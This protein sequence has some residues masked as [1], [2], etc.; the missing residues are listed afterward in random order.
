MND[1]IAIQAS[2][3]DFKL[4]KSR[5]CAQIILELPIEKAEAFLTAFGVPQPGAEKPVA[6][7]LM[8]KPQEQKAEQPRKRFKQM[9][10]SQQAGILCADPAF[11][12]WMGCRDEEATADQVRWNCGVI[13]RGNIDDDGNSAGRWDDLVLRYRQATGQMAELRS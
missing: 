10:R 7:A 8:Q 3:S 13:S 11:Q 2:Y 6:L 12:K 4:I 5:S 9:S 1:A